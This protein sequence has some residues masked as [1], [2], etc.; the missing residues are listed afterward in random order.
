MEHLKELGIGGTWLSPI[1][2]SPM[3]D[4]GYDIED[5][6]AVDKVF[7]TIDDLKELFDKA[8]KLDIKVILDFVP[9]HSSDKCQWFKDSIAGK[10]GFED[11]YVWHDGI[12]QNGVR[13][14]PNNWVS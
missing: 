9:N 7:G 10:E 14:P 12:L 8:N 1:F 6:Y 5:F 13:R 4:F 2:K 11:F 3:V